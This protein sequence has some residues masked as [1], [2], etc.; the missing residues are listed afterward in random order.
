MLTKTMKIEKA[1]CNKVELLYY[2]DHDLQ[3]GTLNAISA[4]WSSHSTPL[5]PIFSYFDWY[6]H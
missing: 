5:T 3:T 6:S 1:L 4:L 2:L